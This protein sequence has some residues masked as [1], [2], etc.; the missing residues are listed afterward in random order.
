MEVV[1]KTDQKTHRPDD[2]KVVWSFLFEIR[3]Y[4][5][6]MWGEY[7]GYRYEGYFWSSNLAKSKKISAEKLGFKR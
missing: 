3:Q 5:K 7:M 6:C 1:N 4:T 2:R